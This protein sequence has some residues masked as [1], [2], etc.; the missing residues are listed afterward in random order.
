ML[1]LQSKDWILEL[2]V[3]PLASCIRFSLFLQNGRKFGQVMI[4]CLVQKV[5]PGGV[6]HEREM[7]VPAKQG[8][9]IIIKKTEML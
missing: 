6:R 2:V 8:R 4:Y 7:G 9:S 1:L 3:N 5:E